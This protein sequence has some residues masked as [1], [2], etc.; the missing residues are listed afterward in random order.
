M[1]MVSSRS[2]S[3]HTNVITPWCLVRVMASLL[4][5]REL[6]GMQQLSISDKATRRRSRRSRRGCFRVDLC[7]CCLFF[8]VSCCC[9]CCVA[10]ACTVRKSGPFPCCVELIMPGTLICGPSVLSCGAVRASVRVFG[11][12]YVVHSSEFVARHSAR[13]RNCASTSIKRLTANCTFLLF[14]SDCQRMR[15]FTF[16]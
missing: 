1:V 3:N 4:R 11:G 9:L 14:V 5:F 2:R 8:L 10:C 15:E 16:S 13:G 6:I 12:A 7:H